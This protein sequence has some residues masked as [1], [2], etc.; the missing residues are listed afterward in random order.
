MAD[1]VIRRAGVEDAFIVAALRLQFAR[2]LGM[3]SEPGFLDR[4]ADAWLADEPRRPTWIAEREGQ[5]AGVLE[6]AQVPRPPWPG[7]PDASWLH[8]DAL[9][10][11]SSHRGHGVARALLEAMSGWARA[12]DVRFVRVNAPEEAT[13][14]LF[15]HLGFRSPH[16]LMELDLRTPE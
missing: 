14:R 3:P 11:A 1:V 16:R 15:A 12:T 5:H 2:D 4:A 10:V 7:R 9:F 8:L 13:R 6:T